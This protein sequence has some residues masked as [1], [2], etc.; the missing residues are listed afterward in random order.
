VAYYL[1]QTGLDKALERFRAWM[2]KGR[3]LDEIS[4]WRSS[5]LTEEQWQEMLEAW[6]IEAY[7][8]EIERLAT[9]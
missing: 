4:A 5:H 3:P 8:R 1:R 9:D 2:N 7:T 6:D